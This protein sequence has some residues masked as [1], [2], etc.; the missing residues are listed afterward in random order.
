MKVKA[1]I[2]FNSTTKGMGDLECEIEVR[3]DVH[4][5]TSYSRYL[6]V[7]A[8]LTRRAL[9]PRAG[10][11]LERAARLSRQGGGRRR[12]HARRR[13]V[14]RTDGDAQPGA[15]LLWRAVAYVSR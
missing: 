13:V 12:W 4:S 11:A 1:P 5:R 14:A 9:C 8:R 6:L 3:R 7:I 10:D 15:P 2:V